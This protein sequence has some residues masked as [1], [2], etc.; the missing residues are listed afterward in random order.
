[1]ELQS[2][3]QVAIA[4]NEVNPL[5]RFCFSVWQQHREKTVAVATSGASGKSTQVKAVQV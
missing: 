2:I 4:M 3:C 1:M 5:G